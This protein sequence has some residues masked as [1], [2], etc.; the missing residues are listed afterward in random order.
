MLHC[1]LEFKLPALAFCRLSFGG[2]LMV[3]EMAWVWPHPVDIRKVSGMCELVCVLD[4]LSKAS[5]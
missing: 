5:L 1:N 2:R 3:A 4:K